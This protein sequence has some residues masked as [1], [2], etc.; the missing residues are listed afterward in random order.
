[1][2]SVAAD[3]DPLARKL[4]EIG[5]AEVLQDEALHGAQPGFLKN[6]SVPAICRSASFSPDV[7]DTSLSRDEVG[8]R[9]SGRSPAVD[10]VG[11]PSISCNVVSLNSAPCRFHTGAGSSS[12]APRSAISRLNRFWSNSECS[13]VARPS[14]S[15]AAIISCE[16]QTKNPALNQGVS[17]AMPRRHH[18]EE[19]LH[20]Q[21]AGNHA[22]EGP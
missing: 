16:R 8:C 19:G 12:G 14:A 10:N 11:R 20:R 9:I 22:G 13:G 21:P 4:V 17:R 18:V 5:R 15:H 3:R 1:M 6:L 7:A 2:T